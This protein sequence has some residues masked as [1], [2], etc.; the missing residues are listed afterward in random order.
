MLLAQ[1]EAVS[2]GGGQGSSKGNP[3]GGNGKHFC[4][5]N[6]RFERLEEGLLMLTADM[7]AVRQTIG[8]A[9]TL[10]GKPGTGMAAVIYRLANH[11]TFGTPRGA[12]E[13]L[14]DEPGEITSVQSRDELMVRVKAAE[15]QLATKARQSER[16][17]N[18]KTERLKV[19]GTV[20]AAALGGGGAWAVIQH[21][22]GG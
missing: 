9:P 7:S 13:S 1:T 8:T 12:L 16:A 17:S 15:A 10:D 14:A 20:L 18:Y 21:F 19:I 2:H 6:D 4:T 11:I 5:Q 3:G 22:V